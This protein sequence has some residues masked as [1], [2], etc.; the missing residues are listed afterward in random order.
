MALAHNGLATDGAA[1]GM[2][3]AGRHLKIL[4]IKES[5]D[6]I[7]TTG[8]AYQDYTIGELV[9]AQMQVENGAVG[10]DDEFGGR[11]DFLVHGY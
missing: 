3:L 4:S 8:I 1:N 10:I 9:G 7:H 6:E 5:G 11:Y 2:K